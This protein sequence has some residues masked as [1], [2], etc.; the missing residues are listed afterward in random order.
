MP[1]KQDYSQSTI[2]HIRNKETKEIVYVGSSCNFE[3]RQLTHKYNC[4]N[5]NSIKH[6]NLPIY[7]YIRENGDWDLFE[8]IPVSLHN[9]TTKIQ[10]R[11]QE[12]TEIDKY[13]HAMNKRKAYITEEQ[14]KEKKKEYYSENA[15]KR[16][17]YLTANAEQIK[18]QKKEYRIANAE[19]IKEQHKEYRIA[20]AEQ[21]KEKRKEKIECSCCKKI[22]TKSTLSRHQKSKICMK[23]K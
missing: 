3:Q 22:V 16:K 6:Y 5:K 11:I 2:Y 1:R 10:L 21:I 4:H 19:Q 9:F 17:E 7:V 15:E 18:E 23:V 20:N 14:K 13:S 12:Q 8:V